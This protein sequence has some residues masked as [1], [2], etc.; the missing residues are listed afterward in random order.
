MAIGLGACAGMGTARKE[1]RTNLLR[2]SVGM[3]K[4]EVLQIMGVRTYRTIDLTDE[5]ITNPYRS[6]SYQ[7]GGSVWQV[8]FYYTDIKA[9]DGA[10]TDD[11]LTPIVLKDGRLDGWGWSCWRDTQTKYEIRLR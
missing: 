11:E 8:L 4:E 10:I 3:T 5:D 7:A 1:N 9:D 6:E 2:L